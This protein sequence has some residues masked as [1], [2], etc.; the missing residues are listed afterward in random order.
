[1]IRDIIGDE[2]SHG[3]HQERLYTKLF[4]VIVCI[5]EKRNGITSVLSS[6]SQVS[7]LYEAWPIYLGA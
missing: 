3:T 5:Y 4:W 1:M 6:S 2:E 7:K